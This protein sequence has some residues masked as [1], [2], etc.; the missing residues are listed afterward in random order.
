M[1]Q[2]WN[3]RG[4]LQLAGVAGATAVTGA[5]PACASRKAP[6]GTP[7]GGAVTIA[8]LFGETVIKEPPKRVVSA[9]YT[10]QDDLL[11]V[12]VVPVAVT[13]WFGDQPFAVWPWARPKMG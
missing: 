6:P 5:S 3:R 11:A 2:G 4:F 9:G 10:E 12:G 1:R 7:G 8:H 13:N